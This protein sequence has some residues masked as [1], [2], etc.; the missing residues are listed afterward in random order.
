MNPLAI[1]KIKISLQP[2]PS[3]K[4]KSTPGN[5]KT[6]EANSLPES[7]RVAG[8]YLLDM[9][10][11]EYNERDAPIA[12][13][14]ISDAVFSFREQFSKYLKGAYPFDI[15][16]G[17]TEDVQEW[18]KRVAKNEETAPLPVSLNCHYLMRNLVMTPT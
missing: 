12:G 11:A 16:L 1:K 10:R 2:T 17:A 4:G 8:Q 14:S 13:L 15:P 18:W 6:S 3:Q 5:S 7:A 9:I